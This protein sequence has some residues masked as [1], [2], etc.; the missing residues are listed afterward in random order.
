MDPSIKEIL[1]TNYESGPYHTHV[2]MGSTRGTY[3][4][5]RDNLENFW[6]LYCG[7]FGKNPKAVSGVA[8]K[9]QGYIPV[10]GDIDIKLRQDEVSD[11]K[12]NILYTTL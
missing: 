10:L 4:F 7:V 6:Y 5:N 11:I 9:P 8:E 12:T 1:Q 2:S 3:R